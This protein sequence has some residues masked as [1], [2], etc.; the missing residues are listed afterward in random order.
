MFFVEPGKTTQ[1]PLA[2]IERDSAYVDAFGQ[3]IPLSLAELEAKD[4]EGDQLEVFIY[5][6]RNRELRATRKKP[7]VQIGTLA[8]LQVE[9]ASDGTGFVNI[10]LEE[11]FPLFKE[12]QAE[13]I[14]AGKRYYITMLWSDGEERLVLTTR[15][16]HLYNDDPAHE[17]GDQVKFFVI[18]KV[19]QGRKLLVDG[20]YPGF[21]HQNDMLP[22]VRRG[23]E[24][25]GY[26]RELDRGRV[27]VSMYRSGRGKVDEA[28]ERIM[29]ML[30]QHR[31]YLRLNDDTDP[32]EIKLRLRMSKNTFKQAVGKLYKEKKIVITRRGIK[33]N[34]AN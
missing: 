33:L 7:A 2:R 23:D 34:R 14:E 3:A 26:V 1:L 32:E 30:E 21:L 27:K 15:I 17:V 12:H 18:E 11:D 8:F 9:Q 6:D 28:A 16:A 5:T 31:G 4:K 13:P 25:T 29:N 22:G 24:Y 10:G 20:K 19:P